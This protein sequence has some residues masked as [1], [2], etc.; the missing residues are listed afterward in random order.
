MQENREPKEIQ[1]RAEQGAPNRTP[2][3]EHGGFQYGSQ[4]HLAKTYHCW[5]IDRTLRPLSC[6][7]VRCA[8][9]RAALL[10]AGDLLRQRTCSGIE[11]WDRGRCVGQLLRETPRA[12]RAVTTL[13]ASAAHAE[14]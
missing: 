1:V 10:A 3:M 12:A 7:Q 13:L 8:D 14:G 9:D 4:A 2:R 6:V 11:V 5:F